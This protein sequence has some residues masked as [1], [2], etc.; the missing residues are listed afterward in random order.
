AASALELAQGGLGVGLSLV[1]GLVE[2]HGG[3]VEARS[4]GAG[5][6]SEFVVRLPLAPQ[7]VRAESERPAA[8]AAEPRGDKRRVLVV[9]D[10]KDS[11]DSLAALLEIMGHEVHIAYAG[12][13]GIATARK[14]KP[15]L[16]L[17]DLG[18]PSPN[19]Y[20]VCRVVRDEF[21]KDVFIVAVTGWG[22]AD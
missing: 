15:E 13:D 6:G 20:E 21:G 22:Q 19:G 10:L 7:P 18:M 2:M 5:K 4:D 3:R 1:K 8:I 9:D 17:L 16:L 14:V 11:A 12:S